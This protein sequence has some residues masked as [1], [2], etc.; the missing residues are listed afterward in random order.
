MDLQTV[1]FMLHYNMTE[2]SIKAPMEKKEHYFCSL[3][4]EQ[5]IDLYL[6]FLQEASQLY[7]LTISFLI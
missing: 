7:L 1:F 4:V 5:L 6:P 3:E 2:D